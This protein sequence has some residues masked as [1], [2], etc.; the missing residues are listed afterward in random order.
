MDGKTRV[1][2]CGITRL[3]DA[4]LAVSLGAQAL[5]FIF[6]RRSPRY[7]SPEAAREIVKQLP[8]LITTVGV[9]VNESPE[10]IREMVERVGLDLVQLHG[11]EPPDLARTFFPRVIKALR[12]ASEEDLSSIDLY[13]GCVRAVLVEPRVKGLYGG[14]GQTL[15]WELAYK[16]TQKGLPVILA[17]GL[18]PENVSE[19]VR[20]VR[21][22]AVDVNS[23]V[24]RAPGK[25]DPE[26]MRALFRR[27]GF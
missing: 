12:L 4:R 10:V 1:K 2:I 3:E 18:A 7:I 23:G 25:K 17:G 8:P 20:R 22:Y 13:R 5:G 21:P 26:R 15:S 6:Y 27:L 11:D 9:F 24:E 16:A 19:A 14:T